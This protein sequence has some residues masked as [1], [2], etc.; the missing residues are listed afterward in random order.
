M[1]RLTVRADVLV[2]SGSFGSPWR[3]VWD[4]TSAHDWFR[5][6][7]CI[8]GPQRGLAEHLFP[9]CCSRAPGN[10]RWRDRAPALGDDPAHVQRPHPHPRVLNFSHVCWCRFH[11]R[12]AQCRCAYEREP[13]WYRLALGLFA[14]H[15]DWSCGV[16]HRR[17][18]LA[19]HATGN[20]RPTRR[21]G[22][23]S[24][25]RC[26]VL[27]DVPADPRTKCRMAGVDPAHVG[28]HVA[29]FLCIHSL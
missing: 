5:R 8:M 17:E 22:C 27:L 1:V 28:L 3:S 4:P 16:A 26:R 20:G 9:S 12:T 6:A 11:D 21:H 14:I 2:G 19:C 25:C 7:S 13:V 10:R 23:S 18:G 15:S 29:A 24:S